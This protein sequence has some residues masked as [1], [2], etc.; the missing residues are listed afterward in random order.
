[1]SADTK[2]PPDAVPVARIEVRSTGVSQT[3][4]WLGVSI[5]AWIGFALVPPERLLDNFAALALAIIAT[6]RWGHS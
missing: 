1:M 6:M 3:E 2:I 4:F 5:L